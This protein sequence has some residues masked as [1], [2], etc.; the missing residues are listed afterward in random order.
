MHRLKRSFYLLLFSSL[1]FLVHCQKPPQF[2]LLIRGG[3]VFDGSG[4]PE[5][6]VDIAIQSDRIVA[7]GLFSQRAAKKVIDATHLVVSPGFI[8]LRNFSEQNLLKNKDP[9]KL[10]AQGITTVLLNVDGGIRNEVWPVAAFLYQFELNPPAVNV[11]CLVGHNT[12]RHL[13]MKNHEFDRQANAQEISRMEWLIDR[14]MR[15]GAFGLSS[16]LSFGTCHYA[17]QDEL[18]QLARRV[19]QNQGV[20]MISPRDPL[21]RFWQS[22]QE[23]QQVQKLSSTPLL[24]GHFQL[25]SSA[26]WWQHTLRQNYLS[27]PNSDLI[28]C[29]T[30]FSRWYGDITELVPE[31]S[32]F[33]WRQIWLALNKIGG[34]HRIRIDQFFAHPEFNGKSLAEFANAYDLSPLRAFMEIV[35]DRGARVSVPTFDLDRLGHLAQNPNVVIASDGGL[36]LLQPQSTVAFPRFLGIAARKAPHLS[37][38]TAIHKISGQPARMLRLKNR[39]LLKIGYYADIT[40]F[41]P[42]TIG[43]ASHENRLQPKPRGI[44]YVIINGRVVYDHGSV[45]FSRAGR[46][47][48]HTEP[49]IFSD[50]LPVT[51]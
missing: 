18:V 21:R 34:A 24:I 20:F 22:I 38:T 50:M 26:T 23:L 37:L 9:Q 13:A 14:G 40:I 7:F 1:L 28:F 19:S 6:L 25:T 47:L 8:D 35:K 3:R 43:I 45:P 39:G 12:I 31:D 46:V 49:V 5:K 36:D 44:Q 2:D 27:W 48:R 41:D 32:Y 15:E 4:G 11:A 33:D 10:L 16:D 42:R 29:F 51:N 17:K 30:P